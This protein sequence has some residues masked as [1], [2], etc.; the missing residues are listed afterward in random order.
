MQRIFVPVLL[1]ITLVVVSCKKETPPDERSTAASLNDLKVFDSLQVTLFAAEPL[2]SN[3]TNIAIDARGRVWVC[4]AYNYRNALNP[5]N[6]VREGGDRIMILEDIDGNGQ[7]DKSKIF[8]Q[9]TDINAALGICVLGNK[10]IVS[11]S[12]NVFVLTDENGDDIADK[13]E[14]LFK[15]IKGEQHDHGIHSFTFGYDGKLYFTMGNE[16]KVLLSPKGDTLTDVEGRKI[17]TNGK[18]FYQGLSLRCDPDGSSIE[19]LGYNFRNNFES[20]VD[21]FGTVWQSDNDDDGNKAT[22]INYVMQHGNFGYTDETTGAGWG[23]RRT[24]MEKEILF[25]HWHLSDPG[26]VP[27]VLQTGAGSPAGIMMYEGDLLPRIFHGQLIHAEAGNHVVRAYTI[28]KNGAG[29]KAEIVNI[30]KGEQDKWFRP[31][32]VAAAPDGSLMVADWYDPGVGGHQ[33]GDVDRGRIYRVAPVNKDYLILSNGFNDPEQAVVGLL[34]PNS[35]VMYQAWTSLEKQRENAKPALEKVW[36][37]A[38]DRERARVF[39]LLIKLNN[40]VAYIREALADKNEDIRITAMRAI[41]QRGLDIIDLAKD[42]A[43]DPSSQVRRELALALRGEKSDSAA[44]M[45]SEL[46]LQYNGNDRWYLEALGIS[47]QG[48]WDKCFSIWLKTVGNDWNKPG[49]RDIVW[50]SRS[51]RAL[52]LLGSLISSADEKEM[53]RYFRAFDFHQHPSKQKVLTEIALQANGD[54]LLYALK[55]VDGTKVTISPALRNKLNT[56]LDQYKN[57]FEYVELSRAFRLVNKT[58]DLLN[59]A[60]QFP[61]SVAGHEAAKLLLDWNQVDE[62]EAVLR[63]KDRIRSQALIKAV[64]RH[65][66][67]PK[68]MALMEKVFMDSTQDLEIRKLAVRTFGGPW[69]TEDRLVLLAKEKRIPKELYVTAAGV[70]QSAWRAN[71]RE[72][73]GKYL[74]LP[75]KT[76]GTK[77]P[78]V[79]EL[80]A[81]K[82]NAENGK[83]VF[84]NTCSRCHT[85]NKEGVDF[86]PDLSEI[87]DKLSRE[88]MYTSILFPD[89]GI[90]FGYETYSIK[91]KNGS[92]AF[93]R[94]ISETDD[95]IEMQYINT[96]QTVNKADIASKAKLENSLMP[97][98]LQTLMSEGE[99]VDLVE[100]LTV[101]KKRSAGL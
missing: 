12:P 100:F 20:T 39:W 95:K 9:G 50:R 42:L 71:I 89:Q 1:M 93:G 4:E 25:R 68:A 81:K 54:K 40:G 52:P 57:R 88:A 44:E 38:S 28:Q 73:A 64:G 19:V 46:A 63:E 8:Y 99:L 58:P 18:P 21:P 49:N 65:I 78:P 15:G 17:F 27:N 14:I 56:T 70:L 22:R 32:D 80:V 62:F 53:L 84:V 75:G 101:Q 3:P 36:R 43:R 66:Y 34:S 10:V 29:Y 60:L 16:G 96:R 77:L 51:E 91:L 83:T 37:S 94:I 33:V 41:K 45:W 87:G 48:N 59:T 30:L 97:S 69:E 2:F 13:K 24:N 72:D 55:H 92:S 98:D 7:A 82:G 6:P 85:I 90:S 35:D 31:V 74:D 79:S 86:G 11:C 23:I 61:D 76:K 26:V 47:A 5:K 67:D